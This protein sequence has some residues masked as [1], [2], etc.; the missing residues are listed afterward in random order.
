VAGLDPER[1]F[2]ADAKAFQVEESPALRPSSRAA[3]SAVS[4]VCAQK[5][6]VFDGFHLTNLDAAAAR[7]CSTLPGR[8]SS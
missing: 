6:P 8:C 5:W 1:A 7:F 4:S 2:A 3:E